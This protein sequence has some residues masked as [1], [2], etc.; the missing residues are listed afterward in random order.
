MSLAS[1][2]NNT[3]FTGIDRVRELYRMGCSH[4]QIKLSPEAI[5]AA[6]LSENKLSCDPRLPQN[7]IDPARVPGHQ[8]STRG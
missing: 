4:R 7:E 5:R 2:N 1:G 6:L 3:K 8:F